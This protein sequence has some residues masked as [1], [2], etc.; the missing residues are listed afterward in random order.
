MKKISHGRMRKIKENRRKAEIRKIKYRILT[1]LD[2]N[3]DI[4][5]KWHLQ[6]T[7]AIHMYDPVYQRMK[8]NNDYQRIKEQTT[9]LDKVLVID[10]MY[11]HL[12]LNK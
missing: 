9:H 5:H 1:S 2:A 6:L 12:F 4:K 8:I 3:S 7:E 10:D 11:C